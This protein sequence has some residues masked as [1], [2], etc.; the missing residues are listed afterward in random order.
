MSEIPSEI[1]SLINNR[2]R[3]PTSEIPKYCI[4]LKNDS[5]ANCLTV[6]KTAYN[7]T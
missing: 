2:S 4:I 7:Y 6:S 3:L 1:D 5:F